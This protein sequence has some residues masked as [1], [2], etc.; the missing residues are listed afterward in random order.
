[1]SIDTLAVTGHRP[2]K[3]G[4]YNERTQRDLI[5]LARI[6]LAR[7][8][9][10]HVITGMA[11]GWDQAIAQAAIDLDIPFT[12]AVPFQGQE[13]RWPH[14]SQ[15]EYRRLIAEAYRLAYVCRLGYAP[16]KMQYWPCGMVLPGALRTA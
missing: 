3:L 10:H 1:M 2:D 6:E 13:D 5:S 12:A 7:L 15:R 9:P 16:W 11:L 4:G 14:D 8:E